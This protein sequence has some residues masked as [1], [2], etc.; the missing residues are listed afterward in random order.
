MTD[1]WKISKIDYSIKNDRGVPGSSI[2]FLPNEYY[3]RVVKAGNVNILLAVFDTSP[4]IESYYSSDK[5][6]MTALLLQKNIEKQ[7]TIMQQTIDS[8]TRSNTIHWKVS[9]IMVI[10]TIKSIN[11]DH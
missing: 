3:A 9:F 10:M 1:H 5:V 4:M 2:F 7:L 11:I 6:N 8:L